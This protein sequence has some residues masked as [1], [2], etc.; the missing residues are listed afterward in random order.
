MKRLLA[1][2]AL[3]AAAVPATAEAVT[4]CPGVGGTF[5]TFVCAGADLHG[6][7]NT[8]SPTYGV[9][10]TVLGTFEC[11]FDEGRVGTTGIG[12]DGHVYV[13]GRVIL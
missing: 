2:A 3:A 8:V 12:D 7:G 10:C 4:V 5:P 13:S 1:V 9:G 11:S 6:D